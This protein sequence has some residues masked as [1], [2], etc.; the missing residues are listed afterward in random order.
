MS[1]ARRRSVGRAVCIGVEAAEDARTFARIAIQR[2]F[3]SLSLLLDD[4]AVRA[5]VRAKIDELAAASEPGDLALLTFSG[6][7]GHT[8]LPARGGAPE[9]VGLWQLYDGSL[10]D[11]QLKSGL[12]RFRQGV[13][14]LVVSDNCN[15]GIPSLR[16]SR[17][18]DS[19]SASVLVMAACLPSK[20]AD[21]I[22]LPGHFA[23]VL[24]R[25]WNGGEFAGAYSQFH[26]ELSRNMPDY[27]K[28]DFYRVG[29]PDAAFEA[30]RPFA[31]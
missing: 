4:H 12:G 22:G 19:L 13:R 28:P 30:Q 20:Y 10:N 15:G 23:D 27:Q 18:S 21:G 26:E 3:I 8:K 11:E 2:G 9:A 16:T 31:I 25:T 7:G 24:S 17:L 1:G 29:I 6:H 14:V 5:A